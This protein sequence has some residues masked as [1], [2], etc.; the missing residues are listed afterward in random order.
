MKNKQLLSSAL[1]LLAAVIWGFAFVSQ[2]KLADTVP[3]FTVNATRSLIASAALIPA[4]A[5]TR[6]MRGKKLLENNSSDRK[7]LIK[8]GII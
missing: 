6:S 2:E 4:A 1:L 3:P 7:L 8:A 5:V